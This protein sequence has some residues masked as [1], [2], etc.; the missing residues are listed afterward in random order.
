[1]KKEIET[2]ENGFEFTEKV[3]KHNRERYLL[4]GEI[5]G[6][7]CTTCKEAFGLEGFSKEKTGIVGKRNC[8]K[9][10]HRKQASNWAKNNPEKNKTKNKRWNNS[11]Q[12]TAS[13]HNWRASK[14]NLRASLTSD[15][16]DELHWS[17]QGRCFLTGRSD[18]EL[19]VDHALPLSRGGGSYLGNLI[20]I[21]KRLNQMKGNQ[22]LIE[23]LDRP[24]VQALVSEEHVE[25]TKRTLANYNCMKV[26]AY[27]LHVQ[28]LAEKHDKKKR[29]RKHLKRLK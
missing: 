3:I 8:C 25:E 17:R 18:V 14:L 16:I 22:T 20:L 2:H 19:E 11:T 4:S 13:H 10:C 1:M 5:V 24:D 9:G 6:L 29:S 23:F 12:Q 27:E 21:D 15:M 26:P 7:Q 28:H